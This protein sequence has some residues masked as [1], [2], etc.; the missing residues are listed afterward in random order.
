MKIGVIGAGVMG[1]GIAGAANFGL[2]AVDEYLARV[3][4]IG[5]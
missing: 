4:L 2:G 5:P 3:H 1:A